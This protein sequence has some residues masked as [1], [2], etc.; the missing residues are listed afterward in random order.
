M[1]SVSNADL[2]QAENGR[3]MILDGNDPKSD[4]INFLTDDD[5]NPVYADTEQKALDNLTKADHDYKKATKRKMFLPH[6]EYDHDVDVSGVT[7]L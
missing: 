2:Q 7:K 6:T 4:Q 3:I 1:V 5:N